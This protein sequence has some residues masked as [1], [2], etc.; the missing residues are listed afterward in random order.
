M[1]FVV[2]L[3]SASCGS[4]FTSGPLVVNRLEP[5]G[6]SSKAFYSGLVTDASECDLADFDCLGRRGQPVQR[7]PVSDG[8]SDCELASLP[9]GAALI[10]SRA[11]L[12]V[13]GPGFV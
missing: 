13:A 2:N 12:F 4:I 7:Q 11:K 8:M 10:V 9:P 1:L 5:R 3:A 6:S